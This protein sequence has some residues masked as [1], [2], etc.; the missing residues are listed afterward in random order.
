LLSKPELAHGWLL[1]TSGDERRRL[2][3]LPPGWY[4][5]SDEVLTRWC[6]D[7]V[8]LPPVGNERQ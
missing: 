4:V 2:E 6:H 8:E 7:A 5:V 3:P 1:F